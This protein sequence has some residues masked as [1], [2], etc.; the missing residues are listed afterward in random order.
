MIEKALKEV[1]NQLPIMTVGGKDYKP[2]VELG[3]EDQLRA[4]LKVKR[5]SGERYY[6]LVWVETPITQSLETSIVIVLATLNRRTDMG[7]MDR[8][9]YTFEP[10]LEPLRENVMHALK[11]S[12][13]FKMQDDQWV[14]NNYGG[15]KYFNYAMT[16]DIWD[17]IRLEVDVR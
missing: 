17:A 14:T 2:V 10:V 4:F 15:E 16:P 3:T 11:R 8:L 13:T 1:L 6:P 12:K 9:D 7:N 5:K